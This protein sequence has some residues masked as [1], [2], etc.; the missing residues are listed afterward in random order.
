MGRAAPARGSSWLKTANHGAMA[1][2]ESALFASLRL[3]CPRIRSLENTI[4]SFLEPVA[5]A[6]RG[7]AAGTSNVASGER[8]RYFDHV[9]GIAFAILFDSLCA[10]AIGVS[11]FDKPIL[12]NRAT[13]Q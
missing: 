11:Q 12:E 4:N 5:G 10:V 3:T 13:Y 9:R 6:T 8:N 2:A 7:R 1:A